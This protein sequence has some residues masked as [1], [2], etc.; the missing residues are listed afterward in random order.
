MTHLLG[1]RVEPS[2]RRVRPLRGS[3]HRDLRRP[4]HR[5]RRAASTTVWMSHGDRVTALRVGLRPRSAPS[6]AP[7]CRHPATRR[8]SAVQFHPEVEPRRT[9]TE[10]LRNFTISGFTGDGRWPAFMDKAVAD[11]RRAG[12]RQPGD[13]RPLRRRR[14]L[15][16]RGSVH[17]ASATQLTCVFVDNG[18]LRAGRG[19]RSPSPPSA[20]TS[21]CLLHGRRR[22]RFLTA[23]AGV[24]DPQEKR[25]TIGRALHRRLRRGTPARSSNARFLAQGTLYPDV[26]EIVGSPG[27][28]PPPSRRHHN[29]GGLPSEMNLE[30]ARAAARALQGRSARAGQGA[31]PAGEIV[32]R[33]P[34]PGPGLAVR[35]LGEITGERSAICAQQTPIL[36][37]ESAPRALRATR[38]PLR[39][40]SRCARRRDGR[41]AHLRAK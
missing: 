40:C 5:P 4:L 33:H 2:S 11:M 23:L 18:L 21:T 26:I 39:C 17:G 14:F 3:S 22:E 32:W 41:R 28:P 15:G 34:F 16:R 35:I 30:L 9:A 7:P 29:V 31:R 37:E 8:T 6:P 24:T 19:A 27:G 38:R 12:R 25:K 10:I 1:G 13:L 20:T 36:P